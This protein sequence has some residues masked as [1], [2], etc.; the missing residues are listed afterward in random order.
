VAEDPQAELDSVVSEKLARCEAEWD[1]EF[2][3][4]AIGALLLCER[5]NMPLP[6]WL[7]LA[8]RKALQ[9]TYKNGGADGRG[10]RGGHLARAKRERI[11]G[12]RW[13]LADQGLK[14]R[15][16][17]P[18]WGFP[19]NRDGAFEWASKSLAGTVAQG[20]PSAVK[21]SFERVQKRKNTRLRNSTN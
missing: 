10:K 9:F 18:S 13:H 21:A 3:P 5:V 16:L 17:L 7:A 11:D 6:P 20:S 8:A 14:H 19:A 12:W 4:A 15:K 1:A 2:Y